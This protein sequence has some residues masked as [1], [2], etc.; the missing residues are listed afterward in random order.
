MNKAH[1]F[2]T[3]RLEDVLSL[4]GSHAEMFNFTVFPDPSTKLQTVLCIE[5]V[6]LKFSTFFRF[7]LP[8]QSWTQSANYSHYNVQ[9]LWN[10]VISKICTNQW[11]SLVC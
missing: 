2:H 6:L 1:V 3:F 10:E 4:L 11:G 5:N 7:F 9:Q 8:W